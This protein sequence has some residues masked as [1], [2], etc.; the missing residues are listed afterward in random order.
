M[1]GLRGPVYATIKTKN[2]VVRSLLTSSQA[3]AS[4]IQVGA[5]P[6]GKNVFENFEFVSN[7]APSPTV[8]SISPTSGTTSGGT[9]V[10]LTAT[11]LPAGVTTGGTSA[12]NI[13]FVGSMK[14]RNLATRSFEEISWALGERQERPR[15]GPRLLK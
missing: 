4:R 5:N 13:T 1:S 15:C 2:L 7:T 10:T 6:P 12:T 9:F 11:G 8:T 3:P 14:L